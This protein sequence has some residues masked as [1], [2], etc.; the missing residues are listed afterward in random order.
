MIVVADEKRFD[1]FCKNVV[2][3]L[4]DQIEKTSE[5][6]VIIHAPLLNAQHR[7]LRTRP[8]HVRTK[9]RSCVLMNEL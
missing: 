1:S 7:I 3:K 8:D 2:Q 9:Q 6:E 5:E 4:E